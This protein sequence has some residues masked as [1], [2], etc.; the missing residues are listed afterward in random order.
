MLALVC[1]QVSLKKDGLETTA[2]AKW[3][4]EILVLVQG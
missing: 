4:P 2:E 1:Q 3:M